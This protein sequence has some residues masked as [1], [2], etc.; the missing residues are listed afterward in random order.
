MGSFL[1]LEDNKYNKYDPDTPNKNE[2][3]TLTPENTSL[4]ESTL[5]ISKNINENLNTLSKNI[6]TGLTNS[7]NTLYTSTEDIFSSINKGLK[8]LLDLS[9]NSIDSVVDK[10]G[11]YKEDDKTEETTEN[12]TPSLINK[13]I[14]SPTSVN[15]EKSITNEETSTTNLY[16]QLDNLQQKIEQKTEQSIPEQINMS[17]E[18]TI[19]QQN[20]EPTSDMIEQPKNLEQQNKVKDAK[21]MNSPYSTISSINTSQ[22]STLNLNDNNIS[23]TNLNRF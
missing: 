13:Y 5:N 23:T 4:T 3:W 9:V 11:L 18:P 8:N 20:I 22:L 12:I 16:N 17:S 15:E 7:Y 19:K 2:I 10:I 21:L 1:S 14:N 6:N